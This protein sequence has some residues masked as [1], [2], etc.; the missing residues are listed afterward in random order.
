MSL[1]IET[2]DDFIR[3]LRENEEFKAA[4]RRELLTQDLLALPKEFSKFKTSTEERFDAIDKRF[5][6]V[7]ER[8]DGI[9]RRLDGMDQRFDGMDQRFDRVEEDIRN[10]TTSV[11][12]LRGSALELKMST[13][14]R[15]RLAATLELTHPRT[16]WLAEHYVQPPG[17]AEE[18]SMRMEHAADIGEITEGEAGRLIDTDMVMR[19]IDAAGE[20][21]HV[22]VEASGVIGSR[23]ISRARQSADILKKMLGE[24]AVAAVYGFSIETEQ[25]EQARA[26][27]DLAEVHVFLETE[28]L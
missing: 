11:N 15:Q 3:A 10:L 26:T 19:A 2:I 17:R 8:F 22:A 4:A 25:V 9:D 12:D 6:A 24:D 28:S 16:L 18:F 20:R 1:I 7:D 27:D 14:L 21:V 5:D 23:D 13:R